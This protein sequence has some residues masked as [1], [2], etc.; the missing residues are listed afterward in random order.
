MLLQCIPA[1]L[2]MA[3]T[4]W[5]YVTI[6]RNMRVTLLAIVSHLFD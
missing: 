4:V 6:Y 1:H 2:V 5:C 3:V